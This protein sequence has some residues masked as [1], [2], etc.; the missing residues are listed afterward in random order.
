M[1]THPSLAQ[2]D[3]RVFF[4][5]SLHN[6]PHAGPHG[7]FPLE[8]KGPPIKVQITSLTDRTESLKSKI[9]ADDLPLDRWIYDNYL[10]RDNGMTYLVA[11]RRG[12]TQSL[13]IDT[14]A[15]TADQAILYGLITPTSRA[16]HS[17]T[18]SY[19]CTDGYGIFT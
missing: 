14:A 2:S 7:A 16:Y 5:P 18:A 8:S 9:D 10:S 15:D 13:G 3:S 6:T 17:M 1:P 4:S 19:P 12:C 11:T